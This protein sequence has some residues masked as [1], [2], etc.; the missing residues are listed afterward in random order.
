MPDFLI[1]FPSPCPPSNNLLYNVVMNKRLLYSVLTILVVLLIA[2]VAIFFVKGYSFSSKN[3]M[4]V[5]TGILSVTSVP[6]GASVYIDGHLTTATNTTLTSLQ[7][8]KY[9][10]RIVKEAFIPWEKEVEVIEGLVTE[11]KATLFPAIPTIYP[12]TVNGAINPALSPDGDKLVFAVPFIDDS[13]SRQKGGVWVWTMSSAPISFARGAEPHQLVAS[14]ANLDFSKAKFTWSPDSKQVLVTLQEGNLSGEGNSRNYLLNVDKQINI[15]DLKDITPI[16]SATT[17]EWGSDQKAKDEARLRTIADLKI[18]EIASPSA[19]I[20]WSPD[21]T[22]FIK[23]N[24]LYDLSS[25]NTPKEQTTPIAGQILTGNKEYTLPVALDYFWLP[26][27][28]HVIL[29][30]DGKISVSEFDG[31]NVSEIYAGKFDG[32]TVFPW[33]D[34]SKMVILTSYNTSTASTPNLFGINLK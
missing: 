21:E 4:V 10:L 32:T 20:K 1:R 8:K 9:K 2:G 11:I 23:G 13:H 12:L 31:G 27:S 29:V 15:A 33:P 5:G 22:K 17:N 7:P 25:K 6:D 30:G 34:S 24:K 19:N 26:D 3:G 14:S 16:L 28:K 18:K